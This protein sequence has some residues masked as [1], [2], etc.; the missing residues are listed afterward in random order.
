M[1]QTSP[2]QAGWFGPILATVLLQ[3]I[4]TFTVFF[5][6]TVAPLMAVEFGWPSGAIGYLATLIMIALSLSALPRYT[7]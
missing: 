5:M 6:P 4:G 7:A 3:F 2:T 1:L